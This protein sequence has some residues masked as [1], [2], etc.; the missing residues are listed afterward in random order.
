MLFLTNS[1]IYRLPLNTSLTHVINLSKC[2]IKQTWSFPTYKYFL[3]WRHQTSAFASQKK[4]NI[5]KS[6]HKRNNRKDKQ[7]WNKFVNHFFF[8]WRTQ[9]KKKCWKRK[10]MLYSLDTLLPFFGQ[11]N[12][13]QIHGEKNYSDLFWLLNTSNV[14]IISHFSSYTQ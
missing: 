9:K 1:F 3:N 6:Q 11:I 14:V 12:M 5:N 7:K 10:K 2:Y 13:Y 8:M 4:T